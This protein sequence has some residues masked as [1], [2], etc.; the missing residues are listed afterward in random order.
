MSDYWLSDL[1]WVAHLAGIIGMALIAASMLYTLRKRR[2][3]ISQGRMGRWLS[4]HH[5]AGFIGGVLA[6]AHT[7]GN[8]TGLG[9]PL[10]ALLLLVLGSSGVYF[11]ESR[12][13]RPINEARQRLA[14]ARKRRKELDTTYRELYASGRSS[15]SEGVAAYDGLMTTHERV[16]ELEKEVKALNG[17]GTSLTWWRHVHNVGTMMMAGVLLVHLWTKIYFGGGGLF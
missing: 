10:V 15:T 8:L 14:E 12:A 7:L 13:K 4:W 6:L 16:G 1:Q 9:L 17:T 2:W 3:L 11:L 5:W